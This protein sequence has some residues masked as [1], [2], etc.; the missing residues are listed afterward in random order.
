VREGAAVF[1]AARDGKVVGTPLGIQVPQY[2]THTDSD[3]GEDGRV[4]I[5]QA[6]HAGGIDMIG[7]VNISDGGF[8]V[9][10]LP[11][12]TLHGATPP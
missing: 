8:G 11:E 10:T 1:V 9:G 7:Y 4:V 5:I 12:F 2:A 6:E 3:S